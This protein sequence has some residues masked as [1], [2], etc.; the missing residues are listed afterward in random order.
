MQLQ[1]RDSE[2]M[3]AFRKAYS[4][5]P[6]SVD[7]VLALGQNAL[8]L[9]LTDQALKF[10]Y[11]ALSL[12]PESAD[13]RLLIAGALTDQGLASAAK[14]YVEAAFASEPN[15]ANALAMLGARLQAIGRISEAEEA[16]RKSIEIQPNQGFSYCSLIRNAKVTDEW[17]PTLDKM[18]R[19]VRAG[20][21]NERGL[22]YLHYGLGKAYDDLARYKLALEHFDKANAISYRL[23]FGSKS[24]DRE[25]LRS[26]VDWTI[27]TFTRDF[28]LNNASSSTPSVDPIFVLGMMRSGTTLVEQILS[29]HPQTEG[30]GE[31]SFWIHHAQE[32][33]QP[34]T[35]TIDRLKLDGLISR[36][37]DELR[38]LFPHSCRITDKMPGNYRVLGVIA[39]ALPV[40]KIIHTKRNPIDTCLSIY[41]TPNRVA[42]P[43]ANNRENIVFAYR[44]YERLM[45][46]WIQVLG[47]DRLLTVQYEELVANP[48][49]AV[50]T[51]IEF[52][53]LPWDDRCLKPEENER[54][55][56]TPSVWQVRQPVYTSSVERWRQYEPWLGAFSKLL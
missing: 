8:S 38:A 10:G 39:S 50:R 26:Y 41:M 20:N 36:Y 34:G 28:L 53:G 33:I 35:A 14:E 15:N 12:A 43:F 27:Q 18:E 19:L 47:P 37:T 48:E 51:M 7:T 32:A 42:N 44:Q 2:A 21:L 49:P 46:H 30:A 6:N 56:V 9:N 11:E 55:V 16:F 52:C 29:S 13:A 31:R 45:S 23:K 1:S 25:R 24:M 22:S 40:A 3:S 54:S 17:R 4:L 5:S